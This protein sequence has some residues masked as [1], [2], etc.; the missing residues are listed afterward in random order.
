MSE[1]ISFS[2]TTSRHSL[3]LLVA[4]QAQ[5]EIFVNESLALID[6]LLH[7]VVEGIAS[8]PP[9]SPEAGECWIVGPSATEAW[10]GHEDSV[11]GWDG[12]QWS[13]AAPMPGL[14]VFELASG[15]YMTFNTGWNSAQTITSPSGG[16]VIDAEARA[17][18]DAILAV[19]SDQNLIA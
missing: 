15:C 2:A 14:R 8:T 1:P 17:A 6:M 7:P 16:S 12:T 4:G 19:L 5:K 9:A 3:P 18:V 10:S 11:T 13:F